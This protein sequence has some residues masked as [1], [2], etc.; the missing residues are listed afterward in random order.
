MTTQTE[1]TMNPVSANSFAWN[2]IATRNTDAVSAFYCALF[3]WTAELADCT[4]GYTV[5]SMG[6]H[7]IAGMIEMDDKWPEDAPTHWGAYIY[8]ED[9]DGTA[10]KVSDAGGSICCEP[11]DA[12]E[13]GRMAVLTDPTG[14]VISLYKGGD[15]MNAFGT[16]AFCWNELC[17]DDTSKSQ[18]FYS[19][20]FGWTAVEGPEGDCPYT[21]F[22]S[23]E[24]YVGGMMKMH[25]EGKPSWIAYVAVDDVDTVASK[26]TELGAQLCAEPQDISNIGRFAVIT[27]PSGG[28][29]GLFKSQSPCCGDSCG[30]S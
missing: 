2:E 8:V 23:G 20:V 17:T 24:E 25:W 1:M 14:A 12:G 26:A 16:G 28:T 10:E 29:L 5:F 15:G 11:M 4:E 3:G 19:D 30:C 27:D 22:Q 21:L 18:S 9:V 13:G 7:P 6:E